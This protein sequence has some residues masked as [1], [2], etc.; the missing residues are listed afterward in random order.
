MSQFRLLPCLLPVFVSLGVLYAQGELASITG[1]VTDSAQAIM[2]GVKITV[3]NV[4]TN[5]G[6]TME[7]N[8]EGYFTVTNLSPGNYEL[9]AEKEGFHAYHET[10]IVLATGQELRSDIK[11][12]IG[13]VND[14]VNVTAEVA[15]LNTENGMIKGAVVTQQEINDMPLNG[16]DFT[17]LA[18]FVPGV[19]AA[20][21]GGGGSFASINGVR[22]DQTN[23][24][25]DG[26]DDRNVRGAA[27]QL[28]PNIDALQEFKME[29]SG[30]SADYGKMA[31]GI[32][33]I[34]L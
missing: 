7:T 14:S 33:N 13:S 34:T 5:V 20:P 1:E 17:E 29:T 30:Y 24:L 26:I 4:D 22:T 11:L 21:A 31:G 18:L 2:P 15:P 10:G 16:R 25:V 32:L 23:F 27:A 9:T 19:V 8:T 6:R 28:R 12:S 3:R